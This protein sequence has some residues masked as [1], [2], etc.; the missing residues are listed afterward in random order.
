[1]NFNFS[2]LVV[3]AVY[4]FVVIGMVAQP[5][6]ANTTEASPENEKTAANGSAR[7]SDES[8]IKQDT[9]EKSGYFR[10]NLAGAFG[11]YRFKAEWSNAD[12]ATIRRYQGPGM[13]ALFDL[14]R[15]R[16]SG[17]AFGASFQFGLFP[18]LAQ[19]QPNDES[20]TEKNKFVMA[21]LVFLHHPF[22]LQNGYYFAIRPG[23][24]MMHGPDYSYY[25]PL[26]IPGF[27]VA[28]G[29]DFFSRSKAHFGVEA[30]V[31]TTVGIGSDHG[32]RSSA[33]V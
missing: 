4:C 33:D 14:G 28:M 3:P 21:G 31:T 17:F 29:Y 12:D 16:K 18:N 27:S 8:A 30:K 19:F 9:A 23:I 15:Q 22:G 13:E 5:A 32:D 7:Q 10:A 2:D 1:M 26:P 6:R 24:S 11:R 20:E 25:F